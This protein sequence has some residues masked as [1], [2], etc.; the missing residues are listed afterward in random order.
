MTMLEREGFQVVREA[1]DG[2]KPRMGRRP[3]VCGVAP[4]RYRR[5]G[6]QHAHLRWGSML[7]GTW[8]VHFP[9]TKTILLTQHDER[10]YIR[11]ASKQKSRGEPFHSKGHLA[12]R[13]VGCMWG[14]PVLRA[15]GRCL[16]K[17]SMMTV[18]EQ[19]LQHT[20]AAG[21]H[22]TGCGSR[23][24]GARITG[25]NLKRPARPWW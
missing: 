23:R 24:T 6:Y 7:H 3:L 20:G 12:V 4:A 19:P 9:K 11:E 15:S 10:Q 2:Q 1:S 22:S 21:A 14:T 18:W 5:N 8:A 25:R 16:P 13:R 17:R